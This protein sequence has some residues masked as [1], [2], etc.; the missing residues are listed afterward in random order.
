[1]KIFTIEVTVQFTVYQFRGTLIGVTSWSAKNKT[2]GICE[3][4][5]PPA[6]FARVNAVFDWIRMNTEG[7]KRSNCED[8]QQ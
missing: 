1:M 3:T 4:T 7:C 5:N 2:T 6:V 8:L